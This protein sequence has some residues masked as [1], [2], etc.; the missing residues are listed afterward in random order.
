MLIDSD[1]GKI[2]LIHIAFIKFINHDHKY[3]RQFGHVCFHL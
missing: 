3:F 1:V 2:F